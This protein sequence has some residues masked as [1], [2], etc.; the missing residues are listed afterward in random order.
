MERLSFIDFI[1]DPDYKIVFE[2]P[3]SVFHKSRSILSMH[4]FVM[5]KPV[6]M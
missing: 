2:K 3:L 4:C 6:N 5:W 1:I